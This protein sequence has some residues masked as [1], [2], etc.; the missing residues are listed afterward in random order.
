MVTAPEPVR[1]ERVL[2]R[3][4]H[5]SAD[6]VKDIINKQMKDS[7][8]ETLADFMINNDGKLSVIKQTMEIYDKLVVA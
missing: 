3:D 1:I 8:K 7:K 4:T 5:R 6:D 2:K